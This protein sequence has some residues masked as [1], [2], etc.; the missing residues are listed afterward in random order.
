MAPFSEARCR[1]WAAI[2]I[3]LGAIHVP[4]VSGS[5]RG[6]LDTDVVPAAHVVATTPF[7]LATRFLVANNA[8]SSM[9]AMNSGDGEV[10]T[11]AGELFSMECAVAFA[12]LPGGTYT[13]VAK[14]KAF[15]S[16]TDQ[17]V[18]CKQV[19]VEGLAQATKD[20]NRIGGEMAF[21]NWCNSVW[22][23]FAE[24]YGGH[25]LSQ[26]T[27]WQCRSTCE[28]ME[29]RKK[30]DDE[31]LGIYDLE[32]ELKDNERQLRSDKEDLR[33][34]KEKVQYEE[35]KQQSLQRNMKYELEKM[36]NA[37]YRL[38]NSTAAEDTAELKVQ[39]MRG[40]IKN[41]TKSLRTA[42]TTLESADNAKEMAEQKASQLLKQVN[43][44]QDLL[45]EKNSELQAVEEE[46]KSK[47]KDV[48][49]LE[50]MIEEDTKKLASMKTEVSELETDYAAK[51][52]A[53]AEQEKALAAE[54]K[55]EGNKEMLD[56][57]AKYLE[58]ERQKLYQFKSKVDEKK[59]DMEKVE[60]SITLAKERIT[61]LQSRKEATYKTTTDSLN[62]VIGKVT[63]EA[64]SLN[65]QLTAANT[66]RDAATANASSALTSFEDAQKKHLVAVKTLPLLEDSLQE[67]Q[68]KSAEAV[69]EE[70]EARN[71]KRKVGIALGRATEAVEDAIEEMNATWIFVNET[72][73]K[74]KNVSSDLTEK[75]QDI[76]G[77]QHN[78]SKVQPFIV[79]HHD[80][81]PPR[82]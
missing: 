80:L 20:G 39:E 29:K 26:C 11:D 78:H 34:K 35:G 75:R 28:W 69:K 3:W 38:G 36:Q 4:Q 67:K 18:K 53:L 10:V 23:W 7:D 46:H 9:S 68:A 51:A 21:S 30:L 64:T 72:S 79:R 12:S 8:A 57:K 42:E 60:N 61:K 66:T 24:T 13:P 74:L 44:A 16:T 55:T 15:C 63:A 56:I 76:N 5:L 81:A 2:G 65:T 71:D 22:A 52:Q 82:P 1:W 6:H 27:K 45:D 47:L 14:L 49:A 77:R 62:Q 70:R 41:L 48:A 32:E 59:F 40:M 54:P 25:C 58:E 31:D 50:L 43:A 19:V 73:A 37:K 17:P 33:R